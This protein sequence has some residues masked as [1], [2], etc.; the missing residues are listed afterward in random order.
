MIKRLA[1]RA[2]RL[3]YLK[4]KSEYFSPTY[5]KI[6]P[7]IKNLSPLPIIEAITKTKKLTLKSPAPI[8]KTLYGIGE[9]AEIK[10]VQNA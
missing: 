4:I 8:V 7:T 6:K 1:I 5:L 3:K 9:K 2:S 10:T